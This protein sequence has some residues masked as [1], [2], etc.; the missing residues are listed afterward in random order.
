[1]ESK[2]IKIFQW[3]SLKHKFPRRIHKEAESVSINQTKLIE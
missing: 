3:T 1:M 2:P